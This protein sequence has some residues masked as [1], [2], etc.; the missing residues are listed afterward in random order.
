MKLWFQS[1]HLRFRHPFTISRGTKTH[2]P[3]LIVSL[4]HL[5]HVGYGEA[6]AITY[7]DISLEKMEADLQRKK[8]F[9]EKFA[10]TEPDRY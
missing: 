9:V 8:M 6:P 10:L 4:E 1:Y 2:Q 3:T 7:Y 5:G